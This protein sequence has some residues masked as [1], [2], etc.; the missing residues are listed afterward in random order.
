MVGKRR[1]RRP[2]MK[3]VADQVGISIKSVSRAL[4]GEPG[5]SEDTAEQVLTIAHELG[6]RRNDLARSLRRRDRTETVG[7]VVKHASTRFFD[8]LIRGID[9]V[10]AVHGALVLT[11]TTRMADREKTTLLAMSSRRVDG[12]VI[13]PT[14]HDQT[15]L[16]AEQAAGLPLVFV[17][18]RPIGISAD[19]VIADNAGGAYGATRHLL[20]HGHRRIGVVGAQANLFTIGERV[21]GYRR[22]LAEAS[23]PAD[24]LVRL[25]CDG[26]AAA[27]QAAGELLLQPE[28]PTAFF[29]LNNVCTIGTARA[30]R[31]ASLGREVALV[32]FDDF[33][34]ADLL[35]PPVTVVAQ[36]VEAMGRHAAELL[37]ARIKGYDG[38]PETTVLPSHLIAR[39]SGE[40]KAGRRKARVRAGTRVR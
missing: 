11:A 10:A 21:S 15:F 1:L 26:T 24:G 33:E 36:D 20:S 5:V 39:G 25:D 22:A 38:P 7:V 37:F 17:D 32:G 40:L 3:D 31:D 30:L 27:Q 28:P 35:D 6:F 19:T 14:G 34:T 12:I 9:E 13:A 2:T 29:C 8:S 16:R 23:L 18:R 4:N